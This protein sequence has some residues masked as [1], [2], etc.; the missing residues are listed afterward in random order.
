MEDQP[1]SEHRSQPLAE[2]EKR[3]VQRLQEDLPIVSRPFR[4]IAERIGITEGELLAAI[5]RFMNDGTIRRFGATLRH[6]RS[7]FPAN[8]MVVWRVGAEDLARV[9]TVLASFREVTH[10]YQRPAVAGWP[11]RLFTM[12]H[13]RSRHDCEELARRMAEK[14]KVPDY[15]LLFT[16]DELKK[17]TM[18]YF[19]DVR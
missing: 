15:R 12:I 8:A 14:A 13:G 2:L 11:Y 3:I 4:A 6:H 16:V 5:R 1:G 7:G 9:A 10:C 19:D 17:T 18:V